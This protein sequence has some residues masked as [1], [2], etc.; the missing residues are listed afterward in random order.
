MTPTGDEGHLR[1][2]GALEPE[3]LDANV[4]LARSARLACI[5]QCAF[6]ART[7]CGRKEPTHVV[8]G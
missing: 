1:V 7:P 6:S 8:V 3:S 5:S 4:R 2:L